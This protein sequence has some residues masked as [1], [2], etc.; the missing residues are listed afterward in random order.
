MKYKYLTASDLIYI[1]KAVLEYTDEIQDAIQYPQGL[2]IVSEQP[3][4]V[5]FGHELYPNVWLKAAFIL[6]KITKKHI[7][8]DGNKR[9]AFVA[10]K[11]FLRK[12]NFKLYLSKEA[13]IALMLEVTT[14]D[15]SQKEMEKVASILKNNCQKIER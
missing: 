5:L 8:T 10:T 9:T 11:I 2:S 12:N 13:G 1:N 7:F 15:D 6:Q 4:M 14:N 3:K